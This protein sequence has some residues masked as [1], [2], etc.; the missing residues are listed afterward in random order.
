LEFKA[1]R[2]FKRILKYEPRTTR[3]A[4]LDVGRIDQSSKE[5]DDIL[6]CSILVTFTLIQTVDEETDSNMTLST[7]NV[8]RSFENVT[9][10]LEVQLPVNWVDIFVMPLVGQYGGNEASVFGEYPI[11][12]V[13]QETILRFLVGRAAVP[14]EKCG[15]CQWQF[16]TPAL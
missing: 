11:Q 14:K 16:P 15:H 2:R 13:L 8:K 3:K 7:K 9:I 1:R 10:P 4:Y 12:E 6:A 5:R